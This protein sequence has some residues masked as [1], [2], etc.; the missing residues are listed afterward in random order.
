MLATLVTRIRNTMFTKVENQAIKASVSHL[1]ILKLLI[2]NFQKIYNSQI[3]IRIEGVTVW[4]ISMTFMKSW[5]LNKKQAVVNAVKQF[6]FLHSFNYDV[7]ENKSDKYVVKCTQYGNECQ[8][9]VGASFSKIHKRWKIKKNKWY[10][11]LHNFTHIT[12]SC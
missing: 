1:H 5:Y 11:H 7:E 2:A 10:S 3:L 8:W 4:M 12:R 9:R 6:H